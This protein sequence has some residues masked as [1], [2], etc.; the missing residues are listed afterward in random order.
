MHMPE[1]WGYMQ[2]SD[3]KAGSG[4]N[5]LLADKDFDKKMGP[6]NGLLRRKMNTIRS[7]I[8]ILQIK[9]TL[10]WVKRFQ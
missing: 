4:T 1:M 6:S 10:V 8:L 7:F 3:I 9:K 2:F 5:S